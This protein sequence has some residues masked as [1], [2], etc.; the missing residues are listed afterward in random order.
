MKLEIGTGADDDKRLNVVDDRSFRKNS[1]YRGLFDFSVTQI[2]I[3]QSQPS[4][5]EFFVRN[6]RSR[7]DMS[8]KIILMK[9][10]GIN[11]N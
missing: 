3:K 11:L 6:A 2:I 10:F 9:D 4:L 8:F 1:I 5:L 7:R